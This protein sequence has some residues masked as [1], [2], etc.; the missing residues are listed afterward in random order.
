MRI[1]SNIKILLG[2]TVVLLYYHQMYPVVPLRI[3]KYKVLKEALHAIGKK[4]KVFIKFRINTKANFNRVTTNEAKNINAK[5]F[6][7][8]RIS[9][10]SRPLSPLFFFFFFFFFL[11]LIQ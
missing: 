6:R 2:C 1:V 11:F 5:D 10:L 9:F 7:R 8:E 4:I 3:K